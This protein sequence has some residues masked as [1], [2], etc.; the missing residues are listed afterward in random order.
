MKDSWLDDATAADRDDACYEQHGCPMA[1][2]VEEGPARRYWALPRNSMRL[3]R[4][5]VNGGPW[6]PFLTVSD[7]F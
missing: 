6:R 7:T 1:E 4:P 5:P 2:A 3:R